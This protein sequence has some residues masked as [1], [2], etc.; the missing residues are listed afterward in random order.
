MSEPQP[1]LYTERLVLRPFTTDDA[2]DVQRLAGA[3]AIADTTLLI[4]HPYPDGAAEAWIA[5]HQAGYAGG[6]SAVFAITSRAGGALLGAM[7]LHVAP[8]HAS[9]ELGYWIGEPYWGRGYAT[10]A[11]RAV[12]EFGFTTL[13]LHRIH[14]HH[15]LRNPQS[16]R[17]MEKLGMRFE[18]ILRHA[19]RKWDTFEDVAQY[20]ILA[21]DRMPGETNP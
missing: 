14:A 12:L 19:I 10:E 6:K 7:G 20:A 21:T 3:R 1:S 13:G 8:A 16:G 11:G 18:G 4:P 9:A 15:M 17:V 5:T 2:P